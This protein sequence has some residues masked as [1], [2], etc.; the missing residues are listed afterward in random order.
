MASGLSKQLKSRSTILLE[1]YPNRN[2]PT[3]SAKEP[4]KERIGVD[5]HFGKEFGDLA[6]EAPVRGHAPAIQQTGGGK[7]VNAGANGSHAPDI[8][9]ARF[10][11][12]RNSSIGCRLQPQRPSP[13]NNDGIKGWGSF[14]GA[15]WPD[16]YSRLGDE[17]AATRS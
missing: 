10:E 12:V 6:G 14:K 15:M 8:G 4:N 17:S 5:T 13:R 3:N 1:T 11:P 2:G 16:D 7:R 9:R